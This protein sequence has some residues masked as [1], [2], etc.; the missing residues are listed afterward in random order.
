LTITFVKVVGS[1]PCADLPGAAALD[2]AEKLGNEHHG[3]WRDGRPTPV[4]DAFDTLAER[5][6]PLPHVG[7]LTV[8][9]RT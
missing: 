2:A 1:A 8:E 9:W 7:H 3:M 5:W 4:V 6:R